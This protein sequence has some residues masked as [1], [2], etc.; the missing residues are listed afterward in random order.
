L[1]LVAFFCR[2]LTRPLVQTQPSSF[3]PE[4]QGLIGLGPSVGS[5]IHNA[6]KGQPKGD[7]VLDRIFRQDPSTPNIFT[8]LLSRSND[9]TQQYPGEITVSDIVPGLEDITSQPKLTV[10]TVPSSQSSYQ[11]WQVLLD[12]NGILGPDG[13]PIAV[14]TKVSGTQNSSRLTAVFDTGFTF[15]QVPK[16]A[17][18]S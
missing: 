18:L 7:T 6:L 14:S 15:N 17:Q 1:H 4:G 2:A 3:Y 8:V 10:K 12:P 16:C 13:Q 5:N 11:H 9:S